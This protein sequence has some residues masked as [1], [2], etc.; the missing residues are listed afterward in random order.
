MT[1]TYAEMHQEAMFRAAREIW[2]VAAAVLDDVQ[3]EVELAAPVTLKWAKETARRYAEIARKTEDEAHEITIATPPQ[4]R[5]NTKVKLAYSD[6]V[7]AFQ[8]RVLDGPGGAPM[9][10]FAN[11]C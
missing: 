11:A 9:L 6:A 3:N 1:K 8:K 5:A 10:A 7:T 4:E 2:K